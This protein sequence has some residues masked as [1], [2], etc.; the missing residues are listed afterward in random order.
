MIFCKYKKKV[1]VFVYIW[2]IKT[3]QMNIIMGII[4]LVVA[5][6]QKKTNKQTNA[7]R[8]I[9]TNFSSQ[10]LYNKFVTITFILQDILQYFF[11][12]TCENFF[13]NFATTTI[14]ESSEFFR[15]KSSPPPPLPTY[16]HTPQSIFETLKPRL[17]I[18]FIFITAT[19]FYFF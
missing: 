19:T 4:F 1:G 10:W 18:N 11:I 12:V 5:L 15:K 13:K 3:K 7:T 14:I 16:T 8:C 6:P 2:I 17:I 9:I